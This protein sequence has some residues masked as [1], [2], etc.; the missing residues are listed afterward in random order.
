[1]RL[2]DAQVARPR[3]AAYELAARAPEARRYLTWARFP[4]V[5]V[6]PTPDGGTRVRFWDVRYADRIFGPTIELAAGAV[7]L[8]SD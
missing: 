7:T 2:A 5:D 8:G 6:E 3:G 1:L 4:A